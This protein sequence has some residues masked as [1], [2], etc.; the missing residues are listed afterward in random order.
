MKKLI[1]I[2][3]LCFLGLPNEVMAVTNLGAVS[4]ATGG[5]GRGAVEPVDGL[6]LN[7]AFLLDFPTKNFSFNYANDQYAIVI[8]D[9]GKDAVFPAALQFISQ[10]SDAVDTRK[11]G[12][13]L[14]LPKWKI[15]KVASTVA[16]V[17]YNNLLNN[18]GSEIKY[19][20]GVADLGITLAI[21]K[22]FGFGLVVN[23]IASSNSEL[24]ETLQQQKTIGLGVSYTYLNFVRA[25][26]DIETGPDNKTDQLVYMYGLENFINDWVVFRIGYQNNKVVQKDYLTAGFGFAGPQF[27]LHYAYVGNTASSS[28]QKHLFDLGIPF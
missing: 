12:L 18:T 24:S 5:T 22:D 27:S 16:L 20:Q 26:F 13:T 7:P 15:L 2:L 11:F 8:S 19:R 17:E 3:L 4:T 28:D 10:K 1:S 21:S 9:N 23:K 14:S 6:L 25:R